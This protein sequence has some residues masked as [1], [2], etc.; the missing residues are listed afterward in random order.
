[1][2]LKVPAIFPCFVKGEPVGV[3]LTGLKCLLSSHGWTESEP[4]GVLLTCLL[5]YAVVTSYIVV[6]FNISIVVVMCSKTDPQI[7]Y[8]L[9]KQKRMQKLSPGTN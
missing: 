2:L 5:S 6:S 8:L 3:L 7:S 9:H 4:A 1:M